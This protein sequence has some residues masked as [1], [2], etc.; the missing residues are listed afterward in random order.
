MRRIEELLIWRYRHH[1]RCSHSMNSLH[2]RAVAAYDRDA[3]ARIANLVRRGIEL[4]PSTTKSPRKVPLD[5]PQALGHAHFRS[6]VANR[7]GSKRRLWSRS[8]STSAE[9]TVAPAN[10]HPVAMPAPAEPTDSAAVA[11]YH[12]E[13]DDRMFVERLFIQREEYH[14]RQQ[15]MLSETHVLSQ[16]MATHTVDAKIRELHSQHAREQEALQ[17]RLEDMTHVSR[18]RRQLQ[19]AQERVEAERDA[20]AQLQRELERRD[21]ERRE[22]IDNERAAWSEEKTVL[23]QRVDRLEAVIAELRTHGTALTPLAHVSRLGTAASH[24]HQKRSTPTVYGAGASPTSAPV[25][26][27]SRHRHS[28]S[29]SQH[30]DVFRLETTRDGDSDADASC[31]QLNVHPTPV[32]SAAIASD[33]V[34]QATVDAALLRTRAVLERAAQLMQVG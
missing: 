19:L 25:I 4:R 23:L 29:V 20:V 6:P 26:G 34:T 3:E 31:P 22:S 32:R 15:I 7:D 30:V 28:D 21:T 1:F 11:M 5:R 12:Q 9:S 10:Q 18:L 8:S 2:H 17:H 14:G 13:R 16:L 33:T 27:D 24:A